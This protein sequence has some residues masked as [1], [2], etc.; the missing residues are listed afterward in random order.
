MRRLVAAAGLLLILPAALFMTAVFMQGAFDH[1]H[2]AEALVGWYAAHAWT[3]WL[4]LCLLPAAAFLSGL[5]TLVNEES[6]AVLRAHVSTFLVAGTTLAAAA[7]L[8]VVAL[9]MAAN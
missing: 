4:M 5:A 8:V 3:L 7:I 9:H 1:P 2:R 6:R